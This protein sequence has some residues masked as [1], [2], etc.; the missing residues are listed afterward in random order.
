MGIH[1]DG[2][3][4]NRLHA[5]TPRLPSQMRFENVAASSE[6]NHQSNVYKRA[7]TYW[8]RMNDMAWPSD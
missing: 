4:V 7:I 2:E 3:P 5:N 1:G 8:R 6:K